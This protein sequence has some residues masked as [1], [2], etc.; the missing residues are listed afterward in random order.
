[1][2]RIRWEKLLVFTLL[3]LGSFVVVKGAFF[4][5]PYSFPT[6]SDLPFYVQYGRIDGAFFQ[7][8]N[9]VANSAV[10]RTL[11]SSESG[12]TVY[13]QAGSAND[14]TGIADIILPTPTAGLIFDVNWLTSIT[15][16]SVKVK[17]A[18]GTQFIAGGISVISSG[19]TG[20]ANVNCNGTSH[21]AVVVNGTTTGGAI[22]S[23]LRFKALSSTL[24]SVSGQLSGSGV[25]ATPCSTT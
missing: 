25:A 18:A 10:D 4:Q 1:M 14:T 16:G 7:V 20:A 15:A 13:V 9:M 8:P 12:T 23:W 3:L 24:W 11:Q 5:Q 2:R 22:G 19:G 17:T 21:I 6:T